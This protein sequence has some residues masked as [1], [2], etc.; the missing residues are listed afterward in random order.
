MLPG[1]RAAAGGGLSK[2][3][4]RRAATRVPVNEGVFVSIVLLDGVLARGV[5]ERIGEGVLRCAAVL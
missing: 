4:L 5:R 3:R 1:A 2:A